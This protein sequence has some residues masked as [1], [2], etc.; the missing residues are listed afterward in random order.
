[1]NK[2]VP[3]AKRE[4]NGLVHTTFINLS[5][6]SI[7]HLLNLLLTSGLVSGDDISPR[8]RHPRALVVPVFRSLRTL[9]M[10]TLVHLSGSW[11]LG[12]VEQALDLVP[13]G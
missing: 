12:G 13:P 6:C 8:G 2:N 7:P 10:D 1:M 3:K 11:H 9:H 5:V 4:I